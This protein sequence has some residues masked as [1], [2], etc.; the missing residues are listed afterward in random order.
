[1]YRKHNPLVALAALVLLAAILVLACTGCEI[2]TA[3]APTVEETP[4]RFTVESAKTDG[5]GVCYIITDTNSGVQY[6][7]FHSGSSAGGMTVLQ[8]GE[9]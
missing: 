9:D 3:A 7:Y 5:R 1:M 4:A 2:D 6:L 8:S